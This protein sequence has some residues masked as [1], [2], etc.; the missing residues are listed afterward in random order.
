MRDNNRG[1]GITLYCQNKRHSLAHFISLFL[2]SLLLAAC[3]STPDSEQQGSATPPSAFGKLTE[4]PE[5]YLQQLAKS[6]GANRFNWA[7]CNPVILNK[8]ARSTSS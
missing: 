3:A 1:R 6:D 7:C 4:K 2:L 8:P 5:W